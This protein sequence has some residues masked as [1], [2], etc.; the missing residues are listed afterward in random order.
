MF[1]CDIVL[2]FFTL[3]FFSTGPMLFC[4]LYVFG[5]RRSSFHHSS[6]LSQ[7]KCLLCLPGGLSFKY[8]RRGFSIDPRV[9]QATSHGIGLFMQRRSNFFPA[10]SFTR[11]SFLLCH[12]LMC[13]CIPHSL[14]KRRE[15]SYSLLPLTFTSCFNNLSK[16][17]LFAQLNRLCLEGVGQW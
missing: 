15:R 4:N 8:L 9:R 17:C 5:S 13:L 11:L 2:F 3:L 12:S 10:P 7:M 16:A 6:C 14:D 1:I